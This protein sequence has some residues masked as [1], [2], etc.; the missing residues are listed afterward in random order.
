M[1]NTAGQLVWS[2]RQKA[3]G[4]M[5]VDASSTVTNNLQFPGQYYDAE[6]GLHHNWHRYYDPKTGRYLSLDSVDVLIGRWNA[7][8][9]AGFSLGDTN[10]YSYV[11]NDPIN[12]FDSLGLRRYELG[13]P[14]ECLSEPEAARRVL[15]NIDLTVCTEQMGIIYSWTNKKGKKCYWYSVPYQTQTPNTGTFEPPGN[16][17]PDQQWAGYHTHTSEAQLGF[18]KDAD[19]EFSRNRPL[20]LREANDPKFLKRIHQGKETTWP[21]NKPIP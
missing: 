11:G 20:Y 17:K 1:T 9:P 7:Q 15:E 18:S 5:P 12:H 10:L 13:H 8:D 4:E 2:Q 21:I 16:L 3:F 6:T 14:R 19:K